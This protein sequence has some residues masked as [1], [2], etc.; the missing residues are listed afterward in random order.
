MASRLYARMCMTVVSARPLGAV[1]I[2]LDNIMIGDRPV[3][4]N[5]YPGGPFLALLC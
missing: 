3:I 5:A 1:L 2:V 4:V